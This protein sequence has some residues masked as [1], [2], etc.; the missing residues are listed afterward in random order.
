MDDRLG[1]GDQGGS[2]QLFYH[3]VHLRSFLPEGARTKARRESRFDTRRASMG[4]RGGSRRTVPEIVGPRRG[5]VENRVYSRLATL[6]RV[7]PSE[8]RG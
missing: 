3:F 7:L 1:G 8:R 6:G 5:T 4:L 2:Q